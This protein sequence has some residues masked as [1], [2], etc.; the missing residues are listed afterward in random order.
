VMDPL[1]LTQGPDRNGRGISIFI[2]GKHFPR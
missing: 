1:T 2:G